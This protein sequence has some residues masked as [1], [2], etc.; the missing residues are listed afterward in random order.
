M[1]L[2]LLTIARNTFVES[3]RQPIFFILVILSGILQWLNTWGTGFSMAS[4]T[5]TAEVTGDNKMLLDIG[6]ATVFVCGMLLAAFAATA[7]VSREIENKTVLTVVS[8]PIGRPILILGKY[9]GVAAAIALAT[10]IMLLFLLVAIR[11]GVMSIASDTLDGPVF[12]FTLSAVALALILATAT[13]YLYGWPFSQTC[14]LIMAPAVTVG[15]LLILLVSKKW[16]WQ[17]ITTDLKP[18]VM[19]ACFSVVI[20]LLVLTALATAVSTR[21]SQVMTIVVCAGAFLFGLMSNH[22][23]GRHAFQNQW[24]GIIQQADADHPM[25]ASFRRAGDTYHL[26]LETEPNISIVP[27][28]PIYWGPSPNGSM[29]AVPA[30]QAPARETLNFNALLDDR[31]PSAIIVTQIQDRKLTIRNIGGSPVLVSRPPTV[32][33]YIFLEPTRVNPLA[34]GLWAIIPNMHYFWLIDAVTQNAPVPISHVWLIALYGLL[35][36][37]ACLALGVLL[38][39]RRD[40]G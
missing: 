5:A 15:Y 4:S 11:H 24:V 34:M 40:V 3:I 22:F 37:G 6:L 19:I 2:Q 28:T 35:Q 38:F 36:I 12:V 23:I 13:N 27:G 30:F 21:L 16:T 25:E 1:P 32:G 29:L 26:T 9:L 31:V 8:K 10:L 14:I 17:P 18:Q 33:D 39:Q 20:A 7:V